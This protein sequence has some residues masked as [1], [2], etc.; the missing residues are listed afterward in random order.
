MTQNKT[1]QNNTIKKT[2]IFILIRYIVLHAMEITQI[3]WAR[4][5]RDLN[6]LMVS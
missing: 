6:D 2:L 1:T 4:V 3:E 5:S